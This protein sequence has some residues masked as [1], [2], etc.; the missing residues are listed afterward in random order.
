[1]TGKSPFAVHAPV[2]A[3]VDLDLLIAISSLECPN[4]GNEIPLD[5]P[6]PF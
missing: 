3:E 4:R 2:D 5:S 6:L 1:M